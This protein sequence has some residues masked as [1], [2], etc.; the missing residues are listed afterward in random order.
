M[1]TNIATTTVGQIRDSQPFK[2]G[3]VFVVV[4]D[5]TDLVAKLAAATEQCAA[6]D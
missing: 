2:A 5:Y 3:E 1:T 6:L 4:T